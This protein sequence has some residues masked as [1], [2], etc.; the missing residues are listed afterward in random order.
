MSKSTSASGRS[1]GATSS[2]WVRGRRSSRRSSPRA[3]ANRVGERGAD[4]PGGCRRFA[5]IIGGGRDLHVRGR[6]GYQTQ[7]AN[8]TRDLGGWRTLYGHALARF[9]KR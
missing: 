5:V 8:E 9:E 7:Q 1:C 3:W 6:N 2:A 4:L